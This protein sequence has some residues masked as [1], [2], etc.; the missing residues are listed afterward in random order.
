M[1]FLAKF[2]LNFLD[3]GITDFYENW[4]TTVFQHALSFGDVIFFQARVTD[5]RS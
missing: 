2:E 5:T 1:Q 3:K 4:G